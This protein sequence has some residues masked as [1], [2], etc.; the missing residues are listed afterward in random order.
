MESVK[1]IKVRAGVLEGADSLVRE[2]GGNPAEVARQIG[3]SRRLLANPDAP[4][5]VAWVIAYLQQAAHYCACPHFGLLLG[6]RQSLD[7]FGALAPLLESA[8][9]LG[10]LVRDI[11]AY[12]PLHTRGA[13]VSLVA[14]EDGI[15]VCYDAVAGIGESQRQLIELG[16]AILATELRRHAPDWQPEI[17]LL[18]HSAPQDLAPYARIMGCL[19]QF[20]A[21]RNALYL[22]ANLLVRP[23]LSGDPAVHGSLEARFDQARRSQAEAVVTR[24]EIVVR[25]LLPFAPCDLAAT[26][27]MMRSS[28]RTL[29]RKLASQHDSFEKVVDRVRADLALSYLKDSDLSVAEIAEIL[30]FSETSALSRACRRWYGSSP[31]G[32]RSAA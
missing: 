19:P 3:A 32:L 27:R 29:Q 11:A 13:L 4:I 16:L 30:Q 9:T 22:P 12:F 21:D 15:A 8:T 23:T 7:L 2:L 18:R 25:A 5:P 31:R 10:E 26:A 24:A 17:I 14:E 6:P 28:R 20:N 1:T